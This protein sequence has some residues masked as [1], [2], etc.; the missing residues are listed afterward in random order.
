SD[1]RYLED[2]ANRLLGVT[3]S[4]LQSTAGVYGTG[5]S[6]TAGLMADHWQLTDYTLTERALPYSRQPRLFGTWEESFG[7]WFEAGVYAEAVRFTHDDVHGKH[8][9]ADGEYV[10]NGGVTEMPGG[11]RLDIKP[12]VSMPLA[13][14]AWYITPTLAWRY[15]AYDLERGLA[16]DIRRK[17]LVAAGIDPNTA[18]PEQ[19]RGNVSPTRHMPITSIDMGLFFDRETTLGGKSYL[20][21]LEPRLFYLNTPYR[22]QTELPL[23]DTRTFTFSWGQLF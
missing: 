21:T 6:W 19:L 4:N 11:S 12:Y 20:H 7:R 15:T 14:A 9:D 17:Q 13:G 5:R 1:E 18:T 8:I 2:F 23:F 10:R 3:A 16:D 22:D